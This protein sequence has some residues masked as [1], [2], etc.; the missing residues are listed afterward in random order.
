MKDST[1]LMAII[2]V[3]YVSETRWWQIRA[4]AVC[5]RII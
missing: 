1:V 3:L 5:M 2:S 4:N